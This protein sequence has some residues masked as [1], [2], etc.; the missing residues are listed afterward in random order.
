MRRATATA[1]AS[2]GV[3]WMLVAPNNRPLG[4]G[5]VFHP[6]YADCY[7]SV[8]RLR[9]NAGR[10][11]PVEMTVER[12]GQWAWRIDLDGTPVAISSRTYLRARECTYNLD[13]FLEALPVADV[14]PGLRAVRRGGRRAAQP[15]T[16]PRIRSDPM[17]G[18]FVG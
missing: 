18:R 6:L 2:E 17:Y 4:R 10:A 9:A 5:A 1:E 13:R 14:V 3:I 11:V 12:N 15:P 7:E 8:M 16:T